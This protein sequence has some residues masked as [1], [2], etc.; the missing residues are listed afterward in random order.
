V[1]EQTGLVVSVQDEMAEVEGG[2]SSACGGCGVDG[3]CGTSLVARLFGRKRTLLRARNP[4]GA[5]P[6]D[7]VV[8]GLPEAALLELSCV[9][10]LVP[11]L[12]MLAGAI[13]GAY[14][15]GLIAPAYSDG[16]S[17][18]AGVGGLATALA[19][20]GRLGRARS[21]DERLRPRILRRAEGSGS[22]QAVQFGDSGISRE[23]REDRA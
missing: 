13:A 19:W 23:H 20:L 6:G 8:V 1:I 7:R 15:A 17:A 9:T 10:Y 5:A 16:L 21:A 14:V 22:G 4:I 12:G 18:L 11:L 2:R 3:S